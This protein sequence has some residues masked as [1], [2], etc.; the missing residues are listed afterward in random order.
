[1]FNLGRY[2]LGG[3]HEGKIESSPHFFSILSFFVGYL[4]LGL[5]K[6]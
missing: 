6:T 2:R 3:H 4:I 5:M 1:M